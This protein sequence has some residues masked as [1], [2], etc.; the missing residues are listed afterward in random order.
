MFLIH[1]GDQL[2]A[3]SYPLE[4]GPGDVVL[5]LV[6]PGQLVIEVRP[7]GRELFSPS[8]IAGCKRV[9][10]VEESGEVAAK[11]AMDRFVHAHLG[12]ESDPTGGGHNTSVESRWPPV[13]L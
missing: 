13:T 8:P 1:L 11:G 5:A 12:H 9:Q 6:V 2:P 10:R 7:G 4:R 3:D